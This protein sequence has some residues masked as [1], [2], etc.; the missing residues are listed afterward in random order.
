MASERK[1]LMICVEKGPQARIGLRVEL[2]LT[3]FVVLL[4]LD[5]L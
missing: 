4:R 2:K 1:S 5:G 3:V